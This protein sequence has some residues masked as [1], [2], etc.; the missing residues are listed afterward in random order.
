LWTGCSRGQDR[1]WHD[2]GR[3]GT[4]RDSWTGQNRTWQNRN[5]WRALLNTTMYLWVPQEAGNFVTNCETRNFSRR[6]CYMQSVADRIIW[7]HK[8]LSKLHFFLCHWKSRGRHVVT[9]LQAGYL[10][11]CVQFPVGQR[12]LSLPPV[13]TGCEI[14]TI[15]YPMGNGLKWLG[16][17]SDCNLHQCRRS[18][19][20][21][22]K[23]QVLLFHDVVLN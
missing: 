3:D 9:M 2:M 7:C 17:E 5:Q 6:P 10:K 4:R 15:F 19:M 13:Q 18:I 1:T 12:F 20:R 21:E 11:I 23:S 22:S 16:L 8:Y 14:H